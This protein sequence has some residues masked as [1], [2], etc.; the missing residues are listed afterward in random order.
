MDFF[1]ATKQLSDDINVGN[2]L[3]GA[4]GYFILKPMK[5]KK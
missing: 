5:K 4:L 1:K 2:E 3:I